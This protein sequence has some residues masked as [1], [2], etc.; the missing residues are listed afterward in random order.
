VGIEGVNLDI[1][2]QVFIEV[3]EQSNFS[4]AAES[5][6]MTQPAV[7]QY[8]KA[9]EERLDTRLLERTN[10]Y[11]SLNK[12]GEIVYQHALEISGLYTQM[13]TLVDDLTEKASGELKIGA[14]YT[15]GEYRLPKII[16]QMKESY[17]NIHP[18]ITIGNS[19]NIAELVNNYQIDI[20]IIEGHVDYEDLLIDSLVNDS[21][22][23]V[24]APGH[25]INE[26]KLE[27]ESWI[28]RETGSGTR[29]VTEK[30]FKTLGISP[31]KLLEFSSTQ[32]I[33]SSVEAGLGISLMSEWVIRREVE[34][35]HLKI[36]EIK[37][38]PLIREFSFITKSEFKT[39]VLEVFIE[40]IKKEKAY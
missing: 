17:P 14:S 4:R 28:V 38:F 37:G 19:K 2:L 1:H 30:C 35:N 23:L 8:I 20:G 18:S 22:V 16:A 3:V 29:E 10:K 33:K 39:R 11:I 26:S 40:L 25:V 5:L 9:L 31:S 12:A 21:L 34:S 32:L 15:F 36:N 6:H 7:S 27:E 24:S 13:Q